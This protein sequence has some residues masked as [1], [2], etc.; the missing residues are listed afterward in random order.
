MASVSA[1]GLNLA[2]E[3]AG[4][5]HPLVCV[6]GNVASK[7]W[8]TALLEHPPQGWRVIA[9]DLPNFGD[10]DS[11]P[12]AISIDRYAAYL[13]GFMCAL[14]I[15][16]PVLLGHSLGGSVVQA[17]AAGHPEAPRGL[18]LLS[19]AAPSGFTT[20]EERYPL[21]ESLRGN[22]ELMT[23]VLA[24]TMPSR[25]PAYFEALIDDALR[26]NPAALTGNPR[27]L[28]R[29]NLTERLRSVACPVLVV[30]GSLDYL[31]SEP[32]A[33][34]TAEAFPDAELVLLDGIGHSPQVEDPEGFHE[35]LARF[36]KG[37][38]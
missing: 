25:C 10:S 36:L 18:I 15:A 22:R 31:I 32:M 29:L 12:D 37:V 28:G 5:G 27:A 16:A 1:C 30:R 38:P 19:S 6:H 14:G 34:E 35:L 3:A 4:A 33:R 20:P 11:M 9:L 13:H 8:F 23:Q 2:Y 26:M 17:Y 21:L 7:R 24:P